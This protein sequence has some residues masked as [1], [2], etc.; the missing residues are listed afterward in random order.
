MFD[1]KKASFF[2]LG[3]KGSREDGAQEKKAAEKGKKSRRADSPEG[4]P[5][6]NPKK[7]KRSVLRIQL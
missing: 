5:N 2:D 1:P 7:G 3:K 6:I 4:N